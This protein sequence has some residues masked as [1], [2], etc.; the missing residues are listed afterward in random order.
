MEN[1][2]VADT[3]TGNRNIA[4]FADLQRK[5]GQN[6]MHFNAFQSSKYSTS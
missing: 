5:S 1:P 4:D 2:T 3:L 6:G